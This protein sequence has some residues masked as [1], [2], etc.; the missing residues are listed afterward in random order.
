MTC[1]CFLTNLPDTLSRPVVSATRK[2]RW[3]WHEQRL[4]PHE[5]GGS[6]VRVERQR[7][8]R[9]IDAVRE[10]E[11]HIHEAG[12]AVVWARRPSG[13]GGASYAGVLDVHQQEA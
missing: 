6:K 2:G 7:G 11:I 12:V 13:H 8:R 10:A 3:T 1:T 4:V 9:D 5:R